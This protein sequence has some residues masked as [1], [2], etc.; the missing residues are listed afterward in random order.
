MDWL[1]NVAGRGC[2]QIG[3]T[4][5]KRR[6]C[7]RNGA[8]S[9]MKDAPTKDQLQGTPG[10]DESVITRHPARARRDRRL[11]DRAPGRRTPQPRNLHWHPQA[12]RKKNPRGHER[13]EVAGRSTQHRIPPELSSSCCWDKAEQDAERKT[14]AP[15]VEGRW[16]RVHDPDRRPLNPNTDYHEWKQI[17]REPGLWTAGCTTPGILPRPC[18]S[19][20]R[21]TSAPGWES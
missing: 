4:R 11:P 20:C 5:P 6:H 12:E 7:D 8:G 18:C 17:L 13:H 19:S 1:Q 16:M 10:Q 3:W 15:T 9:R 21:C 2:P 14:A